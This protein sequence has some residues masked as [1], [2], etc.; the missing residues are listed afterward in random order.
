MVVDVVAATDYYSMSCSSVTCHGASSY[1]QTSDGLRIDCEWKCAAIYPDNEEMT[2]AVA[3]L[4]FT[5]AS[6]S[7]CF[8]LD[9]G[10]TPT[11]LVEIC[12]PD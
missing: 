4:A 10:S 12:T 6:T 2:N 9:A 7:E 1:N 5:R 8:Q 3:T 11:S